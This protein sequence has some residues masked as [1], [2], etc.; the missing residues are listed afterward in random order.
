VTNPAIAPIAIRPDGASRS[1][2]LVNAWLD[3]RCA[4]ALFSSHVVMVVMLGG[5]AGSP[6]RIAMMSPEQLMEAP[7]P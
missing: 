4:F 1:S 6:I 3:R 7:S 5:C 2:K